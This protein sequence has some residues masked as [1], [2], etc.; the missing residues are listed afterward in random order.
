MFNDETQ[1]EDTLQPAS[2]D[3]DTTTTDEPSELEKAHAEAAKWR[4]IAE[5]NK[6]KIQKKEE[7]A[8]P[9]DDAI[10][11]RL[12]ARG[13]VD[14]EAQN[15]LLSAAKREGKHPVELLSDPYF[16][17]RI[18]AM[19]QQR[20]KQDATPSPSSRVP[21]SKKD[22][23]YWIKEVEAGRSNSPDASMR[24]KVREALIAKA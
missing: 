21:E 9:N 17:D 13:V 14:L 15:Y 8:V 22:L 19:T 23:S 7:P 2:D 18:A 3:E 20:E 5:R 12:E 10:L 6:D 16:K 1:V 24:R 11:A 4:A